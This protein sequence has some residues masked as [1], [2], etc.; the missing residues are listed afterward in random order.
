M[1]V[2][3]LLAFLAL[4][5][6]V[7]W[8]DCRANHGVPCFT[9]RGT[10]TQWQLFRNGAT[11]VRKFASISVIALRRDGS[12]VTV[13][14][15]D[16]GGLFSSAE[17]K[18]KHSSLYLAPDRQIVALDHTARTIGRREPLIWHDLPY[19]R[20]S[21]GDLD[22][23]SGILHSGADFI[24]KDTTAVAGIS[25][26]KW[27]RTLGNGG[28]EEIYLAPSLD[29]MALKAHSIHKNSWRVP[30]FINT[31][32][33]SAVQLGEPNADLFA[34]PSDYREIEHPGRRGLLRHIE[35]NRQHATAQPAR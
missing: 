30:T 11:D 24:K 19:R 15:S 33:V 14:E 9:V 18:Q 16:Y 12:T 6:S 2:R 17:R 29:C 4:A 1:N 22:C 26:V 8:A 35:A 13:Q 28:S 20:S 31:W 5:G 32:E 7:L 25:V 3:L 10:Q 34:L 21:V 23:R 27:Y